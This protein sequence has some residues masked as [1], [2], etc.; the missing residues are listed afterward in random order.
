[1]EKKEIPLHRLI[2]ARPNTKGRIEV[3][4]NVFYPKSFWNLV[5][6]PQYRFFLLLDEKMYNSL[7]VQLFFLE[8][9]DPSLF[10]PVVKTPLSKIYKVKI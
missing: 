2:V 7:Y 3:E 5:Y 1:M 9:Y 10:E 6:L 8:R 4:E